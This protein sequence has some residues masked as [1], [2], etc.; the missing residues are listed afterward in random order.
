VD[1]GA[2][3]RRLVAAGILAAVLAAAIALAGAPLLATAVALAGLLC[4]IRAVRRALEAVAATDGAP[5][6][7]RGSLGLRGA[8]AA[9]LLLAAAWTATATVRRVP[10]LARAAGDVEQAIARWRASGWL[11]HPTDAHALPPP[12]EKP[13]IEARQL[14]GHAAELLSFA[15]E[16]E[17]ADPEIAAAYAGRA[18]NRDAHA[19]L[20]RHRRGGARP[21]LISLHGFGMGRL[22]TDL[23]WLRLRGWDLVGL[24]RELG[25]D[26][27]Y[28][29]LP[30]HGL[31]T[32]G[33]S[34]AGFFDAHPLATAAAVAQAVWDV[35]RLAGWL[36]AQ[37]ASAVGVH[38]L[39][40]GGCVAALYASLDGALAAAIPMAPAVDLAEIF[41]RHLPESRRRE[42]RA[43]GLGAERLAEAWSLVAPLRHRPRAPHAARL[44]IASAADQITPPAGAIA[45]WSHWGEP[46]IHWLPGA[47][48]VWRG[49]V[50]LS[51]RVRGHLRDTLLAERPPAAP[52]LS[53]FRS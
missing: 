4:S 51:S 48:L 49:R 41:W 16:Y 13:R 17:C 38:G 40:L 45:L 28:V 20:F 19:L 21:V 12:L 23:P 27:A 11:D 37:G 52:P 30:F 6:I 47:H 43:A 2:R 18:A 32:E 46:A 29:M 36:R 33:P 22:A 25:V 8:V 53:R 5:R 34:G 42:W 39:S 24:H 3:T 15:S 44:L 9:D 26:V 50:G 14:A 7:D 35:R 31:R 1:E 10:D